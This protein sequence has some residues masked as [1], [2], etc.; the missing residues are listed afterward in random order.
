[1]PSTQEHIFIKKP[2]YRI[3]PKELA[4]SC[5]ELLNY[6]CQHV[7]DNVKATRSLQEKILRGEIR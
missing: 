2:N 5:F 6:N 1:M 3:S 7:A 4:K